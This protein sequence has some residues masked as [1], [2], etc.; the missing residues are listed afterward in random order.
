MDETLRELLK[1]SPKDFDKF[2]PKTMGER[3]AV[4][5]IKQ[6]VAGEFSA[7]VKLLERTDGRATAAAPSTVEP[8]SNLVAEFK[9]LGIGK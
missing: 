2:A 8:E 5:F 4:E 6:A 9:A 1:L 3:V 7:I